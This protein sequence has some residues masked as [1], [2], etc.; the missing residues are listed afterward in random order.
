ME[1]REIYKRVIYHILREENLH[2]TWE[3]EKNFILPPFIVR[4]VNLF[5]KNIVKSTNVNARFI[6][7]YE[8]KFYCVNKARICYFH[9]TI[10]RAEREKR[11]RWVK[12]DGRERKGCCC[13]WERE[14]L[15]Q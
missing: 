7:I 11:E 13:V 9:I 5:F 8:N 1:G 12:I 15:F 14:T 10:N 2:I 6:N 3:Y 4:H